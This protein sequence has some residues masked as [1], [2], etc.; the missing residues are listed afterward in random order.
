MEI[1]VTIMEMQ[2]YRLATHVPNSLFMGGCVLVAILV[3][4]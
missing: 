3:A 2:L 1:H 4:F